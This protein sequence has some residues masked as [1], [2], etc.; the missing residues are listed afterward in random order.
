MS[1]HGHYPVN[2]KSITQFSVR[3]V[4]NAQ[5]GWPKKPGY[6]EWQPTNGLTSKNQTEENKPWRSFSFAPCL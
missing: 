3:E 1:Q 2:S 4:K 5:Q 6:M